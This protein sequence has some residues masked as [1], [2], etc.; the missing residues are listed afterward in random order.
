M[1]AA[2]E[3]LRNNERPETQASTARLR[4]ILDG[5]IEFHDHD[6]LARTDP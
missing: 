5:E 2:D 1:S 6:E 4:E 3:A